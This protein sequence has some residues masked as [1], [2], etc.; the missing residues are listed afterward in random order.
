[1]ATASRFRIPLAAALLCTLAPTLAAQESTPPTVQTGE[2]S[3]K[4]AAKP[5]TLQAALPTAEKAFAKEGVDA[6]QY[7]L[8]GAVYLGDNRI[9][10]RKPPLGS[11]FEPLY[12]FAHMN[13]IKFPAWVFSFSIFS[14]QDVHDHTGY[15]KSVIIFVG[16]NN[17]A[18]II[19][20]APPP[21]E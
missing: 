9:F 11:D 5:L 6:N 12:T 8:T 20:G 19:G 15:A 1:M 10:G 7:M 14:D 4:K 18:S 3:A 2:E 21:S 17:Q 16:P 13:N